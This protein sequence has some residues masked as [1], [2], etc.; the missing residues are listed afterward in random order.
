MSA[1]QKDI[2]DLLRNADNAR[3]AIIDMVTKTSKA[4]VDALMEA[5]DA[6]QKLLKKTKE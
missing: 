5:I 2:Q 3:K 1:I 4:E 6:R